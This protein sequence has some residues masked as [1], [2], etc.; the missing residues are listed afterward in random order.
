MVKIEQGELWLAQYC[1][2]VND[3]RGTDLIWPIQISYLTSKG[4]QGSFVFA[5]RTFKIQLDLEEDEAVWINKDMIGF[6]LP[7]YEPKYFVEKVVP[8]AMIFSA[9]D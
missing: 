1:I 4:K 8:Q 5:D 6:F 9:A 7:V 3:P 2:D